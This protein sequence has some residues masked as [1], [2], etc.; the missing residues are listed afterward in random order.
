M[1]TRTSAYQGV[2]KVSFSENSAYVL[3]EWSQ[4]N[5]AHNMSKIYQHLT[6]TLHTYA[7]FSEIH[8]Y[9]CV[10]GV[11]IPDGN[12]MFKVNNR[13]TRA[14]CEICSKLT[15]KIPERR[16]WTHF[17]LWTHFTPCCSVST[18]NFE[19]VIA[20]WEE[21]INFHE[22]QYCFFVKVYSYKMLYI[23]ISMKH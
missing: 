6:Q 18:V 8:T 7:K 9:V 13:N 3:N 5:T 21:P 11:K 10:L 15:I 14:R 20:G 22:S 17:T 4:K 23:F 16:H 12:Y 19:H 2:T 1:R